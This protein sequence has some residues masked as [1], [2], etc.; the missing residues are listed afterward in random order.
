MSR[1]TELT[2]EEVHRGALAREKA[3]PDGEDLHKAAPVSVHDAVERTLNELRGCQPGS[4]DG[5]MNIV[6]L[7]L[8]GLIKGNPEL[9]E[10]VVKASF[11]E[12]CRNLLNGKSDKGDWK[13]AHWEEKWRNAMRDAEPRKWTNGAAENEADGKRDYGLRLLS[14]MQPL[15]GTIGDRYF[16]EARKVDPTN[17]K[18]CGFHPSVSCSEL[19][20][21]MTM[22]AI[23]TPLCDPEGK[24]IAAHVTYLN[25]DGSK[26]KLD[27]RRRFFGRYRD[28]RAALRIMPV[29]PKT[30]AFEGIEKALKGHNVTGLPAIAAGTKGLLAKMAIQSEIEE[31]LIICGDRGAEREAEQCGK[32]AHAIGIKV[33]ICYPPIEGKDWD[34]CPD[35]A[36]RE[37]IE[38][39]P[40]Y[41]PKSTLTVIDDIKS[42]KLLKNDKDKLLLDQ[43]NFRLIAEHEMW[44]FSHN[45]FTGRKELAGLSGYPDL[46]D[47][48]YAKIRQ[49]CASRYSCKFPAQDI[50]EIVS[51]MARERRYHPVL[52]YLDSLEWDG[53][54]RIDEWLMTYFGAEDT[55]ANRA[56]GRKTLIA[57]V[58]RVRHPGCQCKYVPV[59][60]GP[61]DQGKSKALRALCHDPEWFTDNFSVKKDLEPKRVIEKTHGKMLVEIPDLDMKHGDP[62]AIKAML[63]RNVDADR[64]AYGRERT[65]VPRGFIYIG[66]ANDLVLTD[67]TG[68]VRFWPVKCHGEVDVGGIKRDRDLLFAEGSHWEAKREAIHLTDADA[69]AKLGIIAAQEA[70]EAGDEI[71][72]ALALWAGG[73]SD[74]PYAA[75][76]LPLKE[77]ASQ[78]LDIRVRELTKGME[79]RIGSALLKLGFEKKKSN[80]IVRWKLEKK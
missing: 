4:Q 73:H 50:Y 26:P 71:H 48:A 16:R 15:A 80:G 55:S 61:Q 44:A 5:T 52:A 18:G 17:A 65:E 41:K 7:K 36:V 11:L 57:A 24:A 49:H 13:P 58:R 20:K 23:V 76:A 70:H 12:A 79:M 2:D 67:T 43:R 33:R 25:Q 22:A 32:Q 3:S 28:M 8:C 19:G 45:D 68:N 37:T 29:G 64:L 59:L 77:I 40:L 72:N 42:L 39:A 53:V 27:K 74:T 10:S 54:S 14:E 78:A 60:E 66:T 75:G 34:E 38:N 47:D 30:L 6:A 56:I 9:Y 62:D 46:D 35:D 69:D 31:E 63:S 1:S 21:G 51:V